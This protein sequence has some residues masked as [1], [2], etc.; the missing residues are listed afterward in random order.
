FIADVAKLLAQTHRGGTCWPCAPALS[1]LN[2]LRYGNLLLAGCL[3]SLWCVLAATVGLPR[4]GVELSTTGVAISGVDVPVTCCLA[5]CE[6]IPHG[7]A[8][9][10][11]CS[12]TRRLSGLFL[13]AARDGG[14]LWLGQ[15]GFFND[16]LGLFLPIDRDLFDGALAL[17]RHAFF[18]H[19]LFALGQVFIIDV[20]RLGI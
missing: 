5:L 14:R 20:V 15:D 6:F 12:S 13:R 3:V 4:L 8:R 2:L 7:S 17:A 18:D 10:G 19:A 1:C 16:V 11:W 9:N